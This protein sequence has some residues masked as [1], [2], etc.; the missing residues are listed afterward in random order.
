MSSATALATISRLPEADATSSIT[1]TWHLPHRHN[2][3]QKLN[4][5]VRTIPQQTDMLYWYRLKWW[6]M[7][8]VQILFHFKNTPWSNVT[9]S[10]NEH[11]VCL[12]FN[13]SSCRKE[14]FCSASASL[15]K[16][17]LQQ[18]IQTVLTQTESW[19]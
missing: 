11:K 9:L 18:H 14:C 6:Q 1:A 4:L 2:W 3:Y 13:K 12:A 7:L 15:R 8:A 10:V 19:V 16:S 17:S 5:Y